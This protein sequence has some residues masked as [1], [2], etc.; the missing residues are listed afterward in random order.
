MD[1]KKLLHIIVSSVSIITYFSTNC[2]YSQD[3]QV[4]F[5]FSEP[6]NYR[7]TCNGQNKLFNDIK[8]FSD[9]INNITL[10]YFTVGSINIDSEHL[11]TIVINNTNVINNLCTLVL[12]GSNNFKPNI[13]FK[14]GIIK[15]NNII[16]EN[17]N[18][19]IFTNT[20]CIMNNI[21]N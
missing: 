1:L 7:I 9:E 8:S 6:N 10:N 16:G 21:H 19:L 4:I 18:S 11:N 14:N 12:R 3:N 13:L 15:F 5:D 20:I 17:I 2:S